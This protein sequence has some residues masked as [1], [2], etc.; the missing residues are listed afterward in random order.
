MK[1]EFE[2]NKEKFQ[3]YFHSVSKIL[4]ECKNP[5]DTLEQQIDKFRFSCMVLK[6]LIKAKENPDHRTK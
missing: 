2:Y 3:K 1:D 6:S 5:N 4:D